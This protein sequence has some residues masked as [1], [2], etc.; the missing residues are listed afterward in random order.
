MTDKKWNEM[1]WKEVCFEIGNFK[2]TNVAHHVNQHTL[3]P[4]L[5][6]A[7]IS[8]SLF[9]TQISKLSDMATAFLNN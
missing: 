3:L 8:N 7:E 5:N 2:E 1:K 9:I 4:S 6:Y